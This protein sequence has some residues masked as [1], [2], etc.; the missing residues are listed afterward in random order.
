MLQVSH[1]GEFIQSFIQSF[2]A[3]VAFSFKQIQVEDG[4]NVHQ[5]LRS[6]TSNWTMRK[7]KDQRFSG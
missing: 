2:V 5:L 4:A 3:F 6:N 1:F 7:A